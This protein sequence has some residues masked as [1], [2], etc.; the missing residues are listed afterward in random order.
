MVNEVPIAGDNAQGELKALAKNIQSALKKSTLEKI[1]VGNW[2]N[3][4][5]QLLASDNDFGNWCKDNFAG[6]NRHTRQ[7]YM[8]LART[9][10]GELFNTA[11]L[12]SDTAL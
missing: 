7:N 9:F 6:L 12:M 11:N 2:L 1:K 3:Q 8:N 10:G 5:R 4:A